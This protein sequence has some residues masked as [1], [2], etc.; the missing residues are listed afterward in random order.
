MRCSQVTASHWSPRV[1]MLTMELMRYKNLYNILILIRLSLSW[2]WVL[3]KWSSAFCKVVSFGL[4][5]L[6]CV[7]N[8]QLANWHNY[9]FPDLFHFIW[10][11]FLT[12]SCCFIFYVQSV[13]EKCGWDVAETT[14]VHVS[15]VVSLWPNL[16]FPFVWWNRLFLWVDVNC[17]FP[18]IKCPVFTHKPV[19]HLHDH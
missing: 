4:H 19:R 8:F 17:V 1:D 15:W 5:T 9:F 16:C 18:L 13:H 7:W 12:L 3:N 2:I 11:L 10:C 14:C 6:H